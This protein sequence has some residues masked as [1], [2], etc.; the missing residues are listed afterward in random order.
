[1]I[2]L[3]IICGKEILHAKKWDCLCEDCC[4][5]FIEKMYERFGPT[6]GAIRHNLVIQIMDELWEEKDGSPR[7]GLD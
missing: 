7:T 2:N 4:I 1:M 6:E 5:K 3:C